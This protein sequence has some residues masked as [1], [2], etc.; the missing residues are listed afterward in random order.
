MLMDFGA[1]TELATGLRKPHDTAG[2]PLYLAPELFDGQPATRASDIYSLGVLLYRMVTREYP[3]EGADRSEI[4]RAH[5][6]GRV[7]R[8]RD[9]R[10]DLPSEFV[11]TVDARALSRPCRTAADSRRARSGAHQAQPAP[12]SWTWAQRAAAAAAAVLIV[13]IPVGLIFTNRGNAPGTNN[14]ALGTA[15]APTPAP[16]PAATADPSYLVRA[17]LF[18]TRNGVE[19]PLTVDTG[20]VGG[21]ELSMQIESSIAVYA[22]VIN[23]DDAGRSYRLFPLPDLQ[24]DNPLAAPRFTG[25]LLPT[26][27]GSSREKAAASTSSSW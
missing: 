8:L 12:V 13:A 10:P 22:Y 20:L 16:A 15:V 11:Q 14:P 18:R 21:D 2:T 27:T 7:K 4:E 26:R 9:V 5:R 6:E 3:V 23:A 25:S 17:R 1:G 24:P 19:T